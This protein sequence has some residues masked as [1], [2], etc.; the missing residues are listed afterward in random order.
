MEKEIVEKRRAILIN[1]LYFALIIAIFYLL[2]KTFFGILIPFVVAFCVAALIQRPV[3]FLN[4]KTKISRGPVSAVFVLLILG[5]VGMLVFLLGNRLF[6]R[7]RG[8]YDYIMLRLQNLPEFFEDIK[9]W[10]VS[11]I[12]F[13][14]AAMRESVTE[15][16]T[17]FFDN[18]IENGF[19]GFS[20]TSLGIDWSSLLSAGAGTIKDTVVQ[21]PSVLIAVV[22][23]IV[24]S[25]FMTIEYDE[26]KHFVMQQFSPPHREKLHMAKV[27]AVTTLKKMFKA[28]SLIVL[29]TTTELSIGFYIMKFLK[30][31]NSDYLVFIAF[32]IAMIDI[33]PVL[34]TGTVL[35]PWAIYSFVTGSVPLGVGL[36]ILYAVILVIRQIIEPRLVAGQV[37]LSPIVTILAMYVGTKL[38]GVLGFFILPFTV[39]LIKRFND[40]GIIHLFK[41]KDTPTPA[42]ETAAVTEAAAETPP[43]SE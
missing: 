14:P 12:G 38:L 7:V 23:S 29:I 15:N 17:V 37:G 3:R 9:E 26:I 21:I 28:Y 4:K 39:I 11:A 24:A 43:E 33:V 10:M 35:I 25:V 27:V 40:E 36:I 13:L 32:I 19:E 8:F 22:I 6:A 31:Y 20:I 1:V 34:G 30:I 18:I 5:L 2:I 41:D 16:I 42:V